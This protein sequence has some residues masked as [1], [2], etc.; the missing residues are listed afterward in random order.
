LRYRDGSRYFHSIA[1]MFE[2]HYTTALGDADVVGPF[3]LET[4]SPPTFTSTSVGNVA[5]RF[6]IVNL[7]A[8]VP[9]I[10]GRTTITNAFTVPIRGDLN[11]G[12]DFEY[13]LLIDRRF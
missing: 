4:I 11:R 9:M 8:G 6:D 3:D 7:T 5:N 12:F 2:V 13:S 10:V 1:A